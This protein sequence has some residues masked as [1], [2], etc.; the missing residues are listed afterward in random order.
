[1]GGV[2]GLKGGKGEGGKG[3]GFDEGYRRVSRLH[4]YKDKPKISYGGLW[5]Y[6]YSIPSHLHT[7]QCLFLKS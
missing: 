2:L 7:L 5:S 1:M 3:R 6:L 4:D